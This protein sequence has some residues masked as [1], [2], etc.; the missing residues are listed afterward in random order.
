R[1]GRIQ[2]QRQPMK[3]YEALRR[4]AES[5][6]PMM[7]AR[8]HTLALPLD[9]GIT[10]NGDMA[11]L[12]QLFTNLLNNAA[13]YT[14]PGGRIELSVKL[15]R[16]MV[17]VYVRD[18]GIGIPD[19]MIARV[20]DLFV[21]GER[22]LDRAEGGLGVGLALARKLAELH[23]GSVE[24]RSGGEGKGSEFLVR[25]PAL[26]VEHPRS[27][28]S[29]DSGKQVLVVDDQVDS[30]D[31]LAMNLK[32]AGFD[33]ETTYSG[34][35]A[36]RKLDT[37]PYPIT[38]LDIGLPGLN[39][40]DVCKHIRERQAGTHP[41]VIAITG[42]GQQHDRERALAAGFDDHFVKPVDVKALLSTIRS[43]TRA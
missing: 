12:I 32:L 25:L 7:A 24:A 42:Y 21:Q 10:V 4:S 38:L 16:D 20:F 1:S 26:G 3:L 5:V 11:R 6:E 29:S 43:R 39:G 36:V 13:K 34:E 18:N 15:D 28:P 17:N 27:G 33:V 8:K 19:H 30:A 37:P 31:S 22:S 23:G 40:Y 9:Q 35:E 41:L 14:P 2:L